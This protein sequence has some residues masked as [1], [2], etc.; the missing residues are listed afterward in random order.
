MTDPHD[1]L[2][3]RLT[4]YFEEVEREPVPRSVTRLS[5]DSVRAQQVQPTRSPFVYAL[6][7]AAATVL[8]IAA[9]AVL[10]TAR[11]TEL[12]TG[13]PPVPATSGPEPP[14]TT[15]TAPPASETTSP[16]ASSVPTSDTTVDTTP[17]V[18]T[19]P[20]SPT[21]T[22][23]STLFSDDFADDAIGA[24]PSGWRVFGGTW[25]VAAD[26]SAKVLRNTTEG[27]S[28]EGRIAPDGPV[29]SNVAVTMQVRLDTA[30]TQRAGVAASMQD[31][32]HYL[33]CKVDSGDRVYLGV[34]DGSPRALAQQ[35]LNVE[36]GSWYTVTLAVSGS[37]A[38]CTVE[39]PAGT[40]TLTGTDATFTGGRVAAL[41]EGPASFRAVVVDQ[42]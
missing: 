5:L 37:T 22:R 21:T 13:S 7:G 15:A 4:D 17:P 11:P 9:F 23:P 1:D 33:F 19:S 38:T 24:P 32:T 6:A 36:M 42:R 8:V 12:D 35:P 3:R 30:G 29:W 34:F 41:A 16:T 18:T 28:P 14:P 40:T 2:G 31:P 27:V 26:G 39:G 10:R 25:V 20:T